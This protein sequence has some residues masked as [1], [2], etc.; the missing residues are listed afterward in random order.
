MNKDRRASAG[1]PG[2]AKRAPSTREAILAMEQQRQERRAHMQ[3]RK[4]AR[5]AEEK[6]NVENGV[7]G[8]ADFVK[9]IAH[10]RDD[11]PAP[12]PHAVAFRGD[13]A[14][15][16]ICIC[17]RKR[18][19][20]KRDLARDDHDAVSCI[21]PGIVV[22]DCR[23]RVDGITKYL[24]NTRF[25]F[26]QAFGDDITTEEI[27]TCVA[28]PL[29]DFVV[30]ARARATIFAYG[31][32]GSGKTFTMEGIQRQA[33]RDVFAGLDPGHDA[34]LS[35]FEIYGGRCQ[36]LMNE[37]ARLQVREDARGEVNVIGLEEVL[38]RDAA[39]LLATIDRGNAL[40]TTQRTE[41]NDTSSR[42]HAVCQISI[43]DR[44]SGRLVGKL[45]LVD[46]AGSERGQD[47]RSH[48][49][50]LR[51]ESAEINKSLLALKECIRGLASGDLHVP[52]RASKLTMVLRDSFVRPHCK[53][54]MIATVSPSVSSTDH[55]TNTLR[56]ADRVKE[57]PS[58][59]AAADR[60]R[61]QADR[62]SP[63]PAA[64]ADRK[65][66][67]PASSGPPAAGPPAARAPPDDAADRRPPRDD[68]AHGDDA[69]ER[70]RSASSGTRPAR[71]PSDGTDRRR[72]EE[73]R[74]EE[75]RGERARPARPEARPEARP[76]R[77]ARDTSPDEGKF[78][79]EDDCASPSAH[80][81]L[82][83]LHRTLGDRSGGGD[84]AAA[85]DALELH[86]AVDSLFEEEEALL[87]AHM[88]VIQENAELLTEEGRMLQQVQ[89]GDVV[90][91]DIDTYVERLRAILDRKA[92]QISLLQAQLARFALKLR[93]EERQSKLVQHMPMW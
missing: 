61:Q 20:D 47:T 36:D 13:G 93:D 87:N 18:P 3:E 62:G 19:I 59:A 4:D 35:F 27:Y 34:C 44:A 65:A 66:V 14:G 26:D 25:T 16:E 17:V 50:Q 45:T 46:L 71:A 21:H 32:T 78:V 79:A 24:A 77:H 33:A 11:Q 10:W 28:K 43:L 68:G 76:A 49:R 12:P 75:K 60:G 52:F 23:H 86:R 54:A 89:G 69:R 70:A 67:R 85:G 83:L 15:E 30:R 58:A 51:T 22:H 88:S 81:D 82:S 48:S 72:G 2:N 91:Y 55:T 37:R 38:V 42:S 92:E 90:D 53:V 74:G 40:R 6:R 80:D 7:V 41:A 8:D 63:P 64:P 84:G 73:K 5:L 56:Y 57:K 39:E 9:M 31:Q 1:A 29:V